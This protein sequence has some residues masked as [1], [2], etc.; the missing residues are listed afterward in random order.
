MRRLSTGQILSGD[1]GGWDG[2]WPPGPVTRQYGRVGSDPPSEP[3]DFVT[4]AVAAFGFLTERGFTVVRRQHQPFERVRFE[5]PAGV[6]VE[7]L[8]IPSE[9]FTGFRVGLVGE[10]R[11]GVS[12]SELRS[13]ENVSRRPQSLFPRRQGEDILTG[14]G[15][16]LA[17]H[18][19]RALEGQPGI[20]EEAR[21]L[22]RAQTLSSQKGKT[23]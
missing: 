19:H 20:F 14:L 21:A 4:R 9:R 7:V 18:G 22:R 17:D 3:P 23:A 16:L 6:F 5:S 15:R 11:D 8:S 2:C 13:L 12:D 10:P 1:G